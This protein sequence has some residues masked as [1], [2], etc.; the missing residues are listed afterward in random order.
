MVIWQQ[1]INRMLLGV[2]CSKPEEGISH[3]RK[4]V[5]PKFFG[6]KREIN[7]NPAGFYLIPE[8]SQQVLYNYG[9]KPSGNST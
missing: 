9:G 2:N 8:K 7:K 5:T 3:N 1:V 4:V 6:T